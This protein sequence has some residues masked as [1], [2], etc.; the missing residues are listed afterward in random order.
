MGDGVL[1]MI[2]GY[3]TPGSLDKKGTWG[4]IKERLIRIGIPLAIFMFLI[5]PSLFYVM[6]SAALS[7]RYTWLE[8]L[9]L[10]KNVAPGP[11]WFLEVLLVFSVLYALEIMLNM[12]PFLLPGSWLTEAGGPIG[13]QTP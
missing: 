7:T 10:L 12:S 11:T 2:S 1:F 8:N 6:N 9:Y 4:F 13:L 3:V 5:R